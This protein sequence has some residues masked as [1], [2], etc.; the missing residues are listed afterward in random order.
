[1]DKPFTRKEWFDLPLE[2]RRR[3]WEE[4]YYGALPCP[5]ELVDEI[6]KALA[7]LRR[8]DDGR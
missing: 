4:T 3:W 5:P 6:K 8:T 7:A 2:L 1:M